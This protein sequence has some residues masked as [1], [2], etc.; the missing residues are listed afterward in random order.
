MT[1]RTT[2]EAETRDHEM[3][4][5]YDLEY[6]NP[7]TLPPGVARE[8]YV[9]HWARKD[10]RGESDYRI[11]ELCRLGWEPVP[12]ERMKKAFADPFG[13]DPLAQK[14]PVFK[15]VLLMERPKILSDR[16][17]A[18]FNEHNANKLKSLRGVSNDLGSFAS[19]IN[20]IN[21]F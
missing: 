5:T 18:K 21:S 17:K 9:Y 19:P 20:S 8:G 13:R 10:I 11:E 12:I 16:Q 1:T 6:A 15:D 2:R 4:E 7:L 14:F 3:L